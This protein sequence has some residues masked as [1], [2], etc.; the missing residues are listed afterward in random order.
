[1]AE[2]LKESSQDNSTDR[3]TLFRD[4]AV[5]QFKLVV[6][7]L[8]DLILVPI[9]LVVGL[10]SVAKA[11]TG[12]DNEFYKL[13]RLGK[14]SER[15]INL[16]GAAGEVSQ[17]E[18]HRVKFPK[19]DIDT[20]VGRVESLFVEEYRKGGITKQAKEGFESALSALNKMT[21]RKNQKRSGQD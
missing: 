21:Q 13:L 2:E 1:M 11:D 15:W 12:P 5:L 6:D 7:G 9:S 20:I 17:D 10:I 3:W 4:I 16:F 18:K 14:K 8:R 19:D